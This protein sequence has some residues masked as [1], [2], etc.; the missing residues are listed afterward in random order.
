MQLGEKKISTEEINEYLLT[1]D[2]ERKVAWHV[3]ADWGELKILMKIW[4]LAERI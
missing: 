4:D 3:A 1:T 2:Y